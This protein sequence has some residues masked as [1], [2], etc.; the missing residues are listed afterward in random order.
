MSDSALKLTLKGA[1]IYG[2]DPNIKDKYGK[3]GTQVSISEAD[4][5]QIENYLFGKVK[6]NQDGEHLFDAKSRSEIFVFNK[7]KQPIKEPI[8]EVFFADIS[9]L[10]DE[11]QS[12]DENNEL[13]FESDGSPKM[14]RYSKCL[15]IKYLSKV[16]NEKPKIQAKPLENYEDFFDD[17]EVIDVEPAPAPAPTPQPTPQQQG[18]QPLPK[19]DSIEEPNPDDLPF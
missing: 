8:N 3:F 19:A 6:E 17:G 4:K 12:K 13:E 9:I 14:V 7:E 15:A 10:I 5:I 2:F 1:K 16:E 18:L 11:F